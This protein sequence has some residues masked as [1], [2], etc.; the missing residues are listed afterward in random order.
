MN[1]R[2][3][4]DG[5]EVV[6]YAEGETPSSRAASSA[7]YAMLYASRGRISFVNAG[8]EDLDDRARQDQILL[9]LSIG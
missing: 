1:V 5:I 9:D 7:S 3:C 8:R 6:A 4:P 2:P